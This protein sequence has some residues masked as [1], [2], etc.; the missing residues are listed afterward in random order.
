MRKELFISSDFSAFSPRQN[1]ASTLD[2]HT[3]LSHCF[4]N[5]KMDTL[6]RILKRVRVTVNSQKILASEICTR[7]SYQ[8]FC[9]LQ[10]SN[11]HAMAIS[12]V[13]SCMKYKLYESKLIP[14]DATVKSLVTIDDAI[15][16][17]YNLSKPR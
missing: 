3:N 15:N 11:L 10:D 1:R 17:V 8:G 12:Y 7:G 4:K 14:A 16:T 5:K 6:K 2:Y 9:A 13:L